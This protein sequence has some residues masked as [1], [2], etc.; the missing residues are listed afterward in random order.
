M[1][2]NRKPQ[3]TNTLVTGWTGFLG[4]ELLR[5]LS[6]SG[7]EK[8][9]VL[10]TSPPQ[11]LQ[12]LD[13]EIVEGSLTSPEIMQAAV[14]GVS[15]IYHLAGRVSRSEEDKRSMYAVHIDGTRVLC[16]AAK[17]AG[18]KRIVMASSSG[19]IAVTEDGFEIPNET[20]PTPV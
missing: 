12:D 13:M 1:K 6:E 3:P 2:Q 16:E 4:R 11:G 15:R 7:E 5:H 20:W 8:L 19:T 18:V 17:K 9:R 10:T 14:D